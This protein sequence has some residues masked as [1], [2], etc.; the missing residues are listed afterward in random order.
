MIRFQKT[1]FLMIR[2][3]K[4]AL[5]QR[6]FFQ[7][8]FL[9]GDFGKR[10]GKKTENCSEN[11][12]KNLSQKLRGKNPAKKSSAKKPS[13]VLQ[14]IDSNFKTTTP[15]MGRAPEARALLF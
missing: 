15:K 5:F 7:K 11:R 13:Q 8:K 14:K 9:P 6:Q 10:F 4:N 3:Q 1:A 2:S 12:S